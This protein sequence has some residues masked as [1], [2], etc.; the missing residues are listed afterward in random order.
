MHI[1]VVLTR[2]HEDESVCGFFFS[3]NEGLGWHRFESLGRR[4]RG[5]N[6]GVD[7]LDHSYSLGVYPHRLCRSGNYVEVLEKGT[8]IV[9]QKRY[10][11]ILTIVSLVSSRRSPCKLAYLP[12]LRPGP[13]TRW[14]ME[15]FIDLHM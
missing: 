13:R 4:E 15:A 5:W 10:T 11:Q 12:G 3:I 2:E 9:T 8:G 7:L 14:M 6:T 1:W